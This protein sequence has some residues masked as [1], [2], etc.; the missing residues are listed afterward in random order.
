MVR[1]P[2]VQLA[3]MALGGWDTHV[4]QGTNRGQLA[5]RL[6]AL[7]QG[8]AAFAAELGPLFEHTAIVVSSEFGRTVRENGNGGTDHGYGNVSGWPAGPSKV[9]KSTAGGRGWPPTGFLKGA[10]CR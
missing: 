4:N 3:F 8:L 6:R 2:E 1:N 5:L 10:I 9:A 7:G